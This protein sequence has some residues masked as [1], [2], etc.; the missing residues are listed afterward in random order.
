[1]FDADVFRHKKVPLR[2]KFKPYIV[3][4]TGRDSYINSSFK[5]VSPR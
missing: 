3:N 4:G 1:M 5:S 2:P